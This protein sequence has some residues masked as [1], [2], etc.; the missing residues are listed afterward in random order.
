MHG[1][2]TV[3][4]CGSDDG[5]VIWVNGEEVHRNEIGRGYSAGSDSCSIYL[6]PGKNRI[7]LKIGQYIGGWGFG[8]SI[9]KAA[10]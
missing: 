7:L 5:I 10:F 6:K 1:R 9:P 3:L 2:E 8:V 4:S